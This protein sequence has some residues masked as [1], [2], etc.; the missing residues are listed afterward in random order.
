MLLLLNAWGTHVKFMANFLPLA[1][2]FQVYH[3]LDSPHSQGGECLKKFYMGDAM[4]WGPTP[5][6]FIYHFWQKTNGTPFIYLV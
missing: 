3:D 4:P 6:P 2:Y 5:H 1:F